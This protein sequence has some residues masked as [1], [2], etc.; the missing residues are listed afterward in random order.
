MARVTVTDTDL[1]YAAILR[2]LA[3]LDGVEVIV[4]PD[5]PELGQIAAF[6]DLGTATIPSRPFMRQTMDVNASAYAE[7]AG[8]AAGRV[9]D[10][11]GIQ[12]AYATVGER[13]RDDIKDAIIGWETP[14]NAPSTIAKKGFN[15]PLRDTD[16]LLNS[17]DFEVV[18]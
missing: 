16:A 1:G 13:M 7:L 6:N 5:T 14:P 3:E 12:A 11:E 10:G 17:I 2:S 4:G 15:D 8:E 18:T 9:V